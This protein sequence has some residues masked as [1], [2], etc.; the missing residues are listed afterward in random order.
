VVP[1]RQWRPGFRH[2][3]RRNDMRIRGSGHGRPDTFAADA[4]APV[5]VAPG[6]ADASTLKCVSAPAA[7]AHTHFTADAVD[8]A[9][10]RRRFVAGLAGLL[11][12]G[13][14]TAGAAGP[15]RRGPVDARQDFD[16]LVGDVADVGRDVP[17]FASLGAA[18]A[19]A[20]PGDRPWRIGIGAGTWRERVLVERANVHLAGAGRGRTR[21]VHDT[22]AGHLRPDGQPWGT[23]GC[24]TVIVRAPGFRASAL[25]IGNDFDY[26]GHLRDP[27]LETIGANGAQAVALMLDAGA[28]RSGFRDLD[29]VGHQDTLFVDAGRSWFQRCTVSGSVDFVFGAGRALFDDCRLHSRHRPGKPR[30]GYVAAASTLASDPLGLVF[31]RCQLSHEPQVPAGSVALGRAWRPTRDFPDGRYGDPDAVGA[32]L[33]IDCWLDAHVDPVG[34][35]AMAYTDR[36]GARVLLEPGLARLHEYRNRGPGAASSRPQLSAAQA[37]AVQAALAADDWLREPANAPDA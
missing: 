4:G 2:P 34:W 16:A 17:R 6:P 32:A 30:Q 25:T 19:A 5:A 37:Q 20:A 14:F 11:A 1:G 7:T 3:D 15:D 31:R 10:D 23:W 26:I 8:A 13:P 18:L 29:L 27:Q 33:F 22:A 21:I 35:D 12:V 24:A 28:D 36:T 9:C